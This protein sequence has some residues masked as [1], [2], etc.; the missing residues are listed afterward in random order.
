VLYTCAFVNAG[1]P[2]TGLSPT[3]RIRN[4]VSG[5]LIVTDAA[6]YEI[7]DGAYG[8]DHASYD[9]TIAYM[10]RCDGT[11][12]LPATDRYS[13]A[14][15]SLEEG[16]QRQRIRETWHIHGLD[17]TKPLVVDA[18]TPNGSRKVPADGTL[19]D[20]TIVTAGDVQTVTRT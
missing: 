1:T 3:I 15:V 9:E 14:F 13:W 10:V 16:T 6:M 4:A 5:A 18:A 17:T 2:A 12:T 7:G 19:I 11:A 20:Q 8:Y